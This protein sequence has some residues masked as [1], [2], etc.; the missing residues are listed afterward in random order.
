[1]KVKDNELPTYSL[2]L[3]GGNTASTKS[4]N[5]FDDEL[6]TAKEARSALRIG[7]TKWWQGVKSGIYPQPIV[8]GNRCKRWQKS[9]I[10]ELMKTGI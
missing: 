9:R 3:G 4:V 8:L 1:M 2:V 10:N 7:N 6:V 5:K